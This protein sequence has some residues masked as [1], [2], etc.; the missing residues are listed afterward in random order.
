MNLDPVCAATAGALP[1]RVC[2]LA[3]LLLAIAPALARAD[4]AAAPKFKLSF[5][6]Y[7]Y[8]DRGESY[9]G[10]D[11]NLRYRVN[12]TS[13][14]LGYYQDPV[15]GQQ[16]RAGFDTS[17]SL[18]ERYSLSLLPSAQV[19]THHFVGGS[20]AVQIGSVWFAQA[21]IG[22][23]NLEPYAN[24]NFDPNDAV[25]VAVGHHWDDG[26]SFTLSTLRDDRL[27]TGQ[28]HSHAIAQWPLPNGQRLTVDVLQKSG[29]GDGGHVRAWGATVSY[30]LHR[31]F[32]RAAYDPQQNFSSA[33][34]TRVTT[35]WRF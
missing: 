34:V 6:D 23:T 28:R 31:W 22:R 10:Q 17:I 27:H 29:N 16:S 24:L 2:G 32:L 25:S 8:A 18:W 3:V 11:F 15:F 19:A 9:Q 7:F 5:G 26:R 35:G 30:D 4:E 1:L 13:L 20:I 21:G 12:D 33:D 14:W